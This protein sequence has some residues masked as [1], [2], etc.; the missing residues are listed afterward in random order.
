MLSIIKNYYKP[1]IAKDI[2]IVFE[3]RRQSIFHIVIIIVI[4]CIYCSEG[5][6]VMF[7]FREFYL[8]NFY[9]NWIF[10]QLKNILKIYIKKKILLFILSLGNAKHSLPLY[11]WGLRKAFKNALFFFFTALKAFFSCF[12]FIYSFDFRSY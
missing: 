5:K 3:Y 11:G 9:Q 7:S 1:Y 8:H 6:W 12:L 2:G 10:K 4:Y